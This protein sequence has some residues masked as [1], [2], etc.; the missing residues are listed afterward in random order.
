MTEFG[1][2]GGYAMTKK[3]KIALLVFL[4]IIVFL[5]AFLIWGNKSLESNNYTVTHKDIPNSFDGFRIVQVSDLHNTQIGINNRRLI[6]SLKKAE[7]DIIVITGDLIDNRRTDVEVALDFTKEAV[8]IAPCYYITGNHEPLV[9]EEYEAL[10]SAM[11]EQ[12]VTVLEND[13]RYIEKDGERIRISGLDDPFAHSMKEYE[14]L[15]SEYSYTHL[16]LITE[17]EKLGDDD[18]YTVLLGHRPEYFD[19]YVDC[20]A[21]LVLSGHAHGGQIRIPYVGAIYIPYQGFMPKYDEGVF[22]E[23]NTTMIIS[24]GIGNS[25][26]PIRI[27]NR[28]EILT[29]ELKS[30]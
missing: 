13:S 4:G 10:K 21:E 9:P 2:Y 25:Q 23:E 12:G 3:K 15:H 18:C 26:I 24:R 7:P 29:I 14:H 17:L 8:K 28:P 5:I 1:V 27:F 20:G 30:E 22:T 11:V 16:Y 6:K 19:Y